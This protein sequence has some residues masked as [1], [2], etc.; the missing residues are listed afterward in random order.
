M[1][2]AN[3]S[4]SE[5]ELIFKR[6]KSIP[7]NKVCFDCNSKNPSWASITYGVFI[8]ID[9]SAV[10]RG[11]GVHVSFVRSTQLDTNWSWTQLR[12]MQ[13]GGNANAH[14]F[15]RQHKC[16]TSDAQQKYHSRT[17]QL[18]RDKLNQAAKAAIAAH[19]TQLHVDSVMDKTNEPKKEP[20]FFEEH[21]TSSDSWTMSTPTKKDTSPS[22]FVETANKISPSA[23]L[24]AGGG[25][26]HSSALLSDSAN[27]SSGKPS[28]TPVA[29]YS[30]GGKRHHFGAKKTGFGAQ[31][32]NTNFADV[33]RDAEI[34]ERIKF[35]E[36]SVTPIEP[37]V[38]GDEK[39]PLSSKFTYEE[40]CMEQKKIEEELKL[41]STKKADQIDRLGIG[42]N[43]RQDISH[44]I[45]SDMESLEVSSPVKKPSSFMLDKLEKHDDEFEEFYT[46]SQPLYADNFSDV[47]K[48]ID[49]CIEEFN[50]KEKSSLADLSNK[51]SSAEIME[52]TPLEEE[53]RRTQKTKSQS[54]SSSASYGDDMGEA[55]KKFGAAKSISSAQYF[56]DNP[57]SGAEKVNLCQFEGSSSISS[58]ELF[59]RQT[60]EHPSS[61]Q[62]PDFDDVKESVRQGVTRVAGKL[63]SF[64]NGV[65]S[66]IQDKYGGF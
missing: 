6:L 22:N 1:V 15:F 9:C 13:V 58:A 31:R 19:G 24:S 30:M 23:S 45:L 65:M 27:L 66:S 12:Q 34:A 5:I 60:N 48:Q 10:H 29:K 3:P 51:S 41:S 7:T 57:E 28:A 14:S 54:K 38:G 37:S 44:S 53:P 32:V 43:R 52:I 16:T 50:N 25:K 35:S 8:C 64:A 47:K 62:T 21:T 36:K 55:Q 49:L 40:I 39:E 59:G 17:A 11:L 46:F 4:K 56:G 63:S 2:T 61:I 20:D 33:E 42:F 26:L 18:Y